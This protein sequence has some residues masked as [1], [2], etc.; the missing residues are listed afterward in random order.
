MA[1][2]SIPGFGSRLKAARVALGLRQSDIADS[3]GITKYSV[4]N[5]ECGDACPTLAIFRQMCMKTGMSADQLLDLD[6]A[7]ISPE[8]YA[9]IE[10]IRNL[11]PKR[12]QMLSDMIDHLDDLRPA[13]PADD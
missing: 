6:R 11:G 10:R 13:A 5:W 1:K 12:V 7:V 4:S 9:L 8:E 2:E 3:L